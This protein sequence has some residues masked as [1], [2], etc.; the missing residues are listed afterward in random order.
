VTN[1]AFRLC[2]EARPGQV[3]AAKRV[4]AVVEELVDV[5]VVGDLALKGFSRPVPTVAL[6]KVRDR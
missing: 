6:L 1:L 3:L 2:S 4:V 5:E